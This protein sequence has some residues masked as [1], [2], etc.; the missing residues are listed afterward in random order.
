MRLINNI[1]SHLRKKHGLPENFLFFRWQV[2]PDDGPAIYY[3]VEGGIVTSTYKSGPRKGSPNYSKATDRKLFRM[4]V[5]QYRQLF[6]DTKPT[7]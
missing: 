3:E 4:T 2:L 1:E 6:P 7:N 5:E